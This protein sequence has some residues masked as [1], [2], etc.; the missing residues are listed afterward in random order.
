MNIGFRIAMLFGVLL[1]AG[2]VGVM[3]Y[4]AGV[5]QGIVQSG[6]VVVAPAAPGAYPYAYP[7]YGWHPWGFG[8][9]FGPLLLMFLLFGVIRAAFWR[10]AWH[11]HGMQAGCGPWGRFDE[12]HRQSHE[13]MDGGAT[14]R[15]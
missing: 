6:K 9:F 8:F 10:A 4:N 1:L 12:W 5:Q 3:A 2:L 11:R 14:P 13:R 15:Q 7:Y